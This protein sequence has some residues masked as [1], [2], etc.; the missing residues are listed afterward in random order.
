MQQDRPLRSEADLGHGRYG[1]SDY[2]AR[3]PGIEQADPLNIRAR[4]ERSECAAEHIG[5]TQKK[6][7]FDAGRSEAAGLRLLQVVAQ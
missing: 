2:H 1:S 4:Q 3:Q 6:H 7:Q 5:P